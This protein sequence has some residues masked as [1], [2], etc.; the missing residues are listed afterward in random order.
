VAAAAPPPILARAQSPQAPLKEEA[1]AAQ[2]KSKVEITGAR[3]KRDST[4]WLQDIERLLIEGN[5]ED[6]L[7]EWEKFRVAYPTEVV[8]PEL[9]AKLKVLEH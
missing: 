5:N 1:G 3:I 7:K 2:R 6:A 8:G 9:E 4:A